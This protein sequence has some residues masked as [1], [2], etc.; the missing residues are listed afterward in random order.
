M[1]LAE[2]SVSDVP[3]ASSSISNA[4]V[5][6][7]TSVASMQKGAPTAADRPLGTEPEMTTSPT[8]LS[9]ATTAVML[10]PTRLAPLGGMRVTSR[11][12]A[13]G[14]R[15]RRFARVHI[16][17]ADASSPRLLWCGSII[18]ISGLVSGHHEASPLPTTGAPGRTNGAGP[19]FVPGVAPLS[20]SPL[21]PY[22]EKQRA[23]IT[24]QPLLT[25]PP[26]PHSTCQPSPVHS[27]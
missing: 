13:S 9:S 3:H 16:P 17:G 19:A 8:R 7:F 6:S 14:V 26:P 1:C 11:R 12:H 15:A 18:A 20:G 5:P 2:L 10:S 24:D 27:P 4:L 25:R 23:P 22:P 21:L